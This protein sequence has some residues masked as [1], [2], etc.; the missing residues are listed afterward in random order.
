MNEKIKDISTF[1]ISILFF[2]CLLLIINFIPQSLIKDNIIK[3]VQNIKTYEEYELNKL[4][5]IRTNNLEELY[6]IEVL[7]YHN[8]SDNINSTLSANYNQIRKNDTDY[9]ST[10][11]N[12]MNINSGLDS[13]GQYWNGMNIIL[14]P[15]FILFSLTQ[16]KIILGIFLFLLIGLYIYLCEK[17]NLRRLWISYIIGAIMTG[18]FLTPISLEYIWT[19]L[20]M[21]VGANLILLIKKDMPSLFVIFG[22]TTAFFTHHTNAL[23]IFMVMLLTYFEKYKTNENFKKCIIS[24]FKLFI[25]W[26]ISFVLTIALKWILTSIFCNVNLDLINEHKL[27]LSTFQLVFNSIYLNISRL[28]PLN[29]NNS[30]TANMIIFIVVIVVYM[31][32]LYI[33][34]TKNINRKK[35][36]LYSYVAFLPIINLIID[37]NYFYIYSFS[38]Y[39][40]FLGTIMCAILIAF[41]MS[42]FCKSKDNAVSNTVTK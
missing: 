10:V 5:Q 36:T 35:I 37:Y 39:R 1:I 2:I 11:Q 26:M 3:S 18:V 31:Y 20:V 32:F 22:V 4:P 9:I 23:I 34:K 29:P 8:S 25:K 30:S 21:M 6:M 33:Y 19:F 16:I 14:R 15:L 40:I 13:Y 12:M 17:N 42:G 7:Y 38:T 24:I 41:E 27:D 28:Y